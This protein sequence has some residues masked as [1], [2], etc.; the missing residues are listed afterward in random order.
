MVKLTPAII[1]RQIKLFT[2]KIKTTNIELKCRMDAVI[3]I[4]PNIEIG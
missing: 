2:T 3:I 1:L 4:L